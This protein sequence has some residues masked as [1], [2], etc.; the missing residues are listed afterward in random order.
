MKLST[1]LS[2]AMVALVAFTAAI[3]GMSSYRTIEVA[4]VPAALERLAA[5][6]RL[7]KAHGCATLN[8]CRR[9]SPKCHRLKAIGA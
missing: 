8:T 5:H 6:T 1:R 3:I 7:H 9:V 2:I 4:L